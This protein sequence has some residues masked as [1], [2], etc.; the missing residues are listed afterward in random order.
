MLEVREA[1]ELLIPLGI[2]KEI[3]I[4]VSFIKVILKDI[5]I[6]FNSNTT[7]QVY[8]TFNSLEN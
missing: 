4:A 1:V 2:S 8:I 7:E 5:S 6:S 3:D